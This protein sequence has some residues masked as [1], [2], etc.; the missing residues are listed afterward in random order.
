[1]KDTGYFL[2][3]RHV[4]LP[5]WRGKKEAWFLILSPCD[6]LPKSPSRWPEVGS[7][8]GGSC[9]AECK[10]PGPRGV[11]GTEG[12]PLAFPWVLPF[13]SYQPFLSQAPRL[14]NGI[15][16]WCCCIYLFKNKDY[17]SKR[18]QKLWVSEASWLSFV[19]FP[20]SSLS[21]ARACPSPLDFDKWTTSLRGNIPFSQWVVAGGCSFLD[22]L[23]LVCT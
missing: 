3:L 23:Q 11:W 13:S 8:W 5:E 1:M 7:P 17:F 21:P 14:H 6:T 2:K 4:W 10:G 12:R 20:S 15:P 22:H 16:I 9:G 18:N 19:L